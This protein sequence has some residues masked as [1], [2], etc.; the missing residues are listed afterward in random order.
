VTR[1][2]IV[3]PPGTGKTKHGIDLVADAIEYSGVHPSRILYASFT[4]AAS[5][6]ARDR[7]LS[8]FTQFSEDD[9]P[10]FRT[11]HSIA[12][13]K[14]N[15]DRNAMFDRHHIKGFAK[16]F[17]Y[18]FSEDTTDRD[19][20]SQDMME[21]TLGT[22]ADAYLAFDEWRKNRLLTDFDE[23]Y[24]AFQR[25]KIAL[26]GDFRIS[27]LR[28]FLE[29]KEQYKQKEGLWEFS[30]LLLQVYQ[31]PSPLGVD[32]V[33]IDEAQ[34]N[35]PLLHAVASIWSR[36][37]GEVYW[38]GDPDQS[39]YSFIGADPSLMIDMER[40][41]DIV[42]KQSHRCSRAVHGLSRKVVGRM[43]MRYHSDFAPTNSDGLVTKM[44]MGKLRL[45]GDETVFALFRTRYLM[46]EFYD[47]LIQRGI[48]FTTRRGRQSPLDRAGGDVILSLAKLASDERISMGELHR[49][50]REIPQHPHM[51]RGAK[52][53]IAQRAK[54]DPGHMVSLV[55]LPAL[56]FNSDFIRA[57]AAGEYLECLKIEPE[58]KR[59]FRNLL[60]NYGRRALEDKP[61]LQI[62][63]IH[64]S[65]GLEA[66]RVI[67]STEMTRMPYENLTVSPD[68]EHRVFYVGV[69]RARE[70]VDLLL[71]ETWRTYPL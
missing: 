17:N 34:D 65:K 27:A 16:A 68:S 48:P 10:Y 21:M 13:R 58:E 23:A 35:S 51:R 63:T 15:L 11:L 7:A 69:T 64:S 19:L 20:F 53:D 41:E 61:K 29:R 37:A 22:E 56:G 59:Y 6:E 26:P 1:H 60:K 8:R 24:K 46:D 32:F 57:L 25:D 62:G 66:D 33:V 42:L 38:I 47:Y 45:D 3:G 39:I 71:P 55:S 30:D 67:L 12:F 43:K 14:L 4:R 9:F 31:N 36:G 70:R 28:L 50:V 2:L 18:R 54:E 40:D 44:S 5:Y 49:V 52:Q